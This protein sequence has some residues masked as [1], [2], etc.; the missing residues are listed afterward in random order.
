M[1]R[2][3]DYT[4]QELARLLALVSMADDDFFLRFLDNAISDSATFTDPEEPES[5]FAA[6]CLPHD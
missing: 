6:D 2:F 1:N 3:R 5:L 4:D